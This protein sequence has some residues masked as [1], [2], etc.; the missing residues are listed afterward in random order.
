MN[1]RTANSAVDAYD[2]HTELIKAVRSK[3]FGDAED[4]LRCV[5][6]DIETAK[7][8]RTEQLL[9]CAQIFEVEDLMLSEA[10]TIFVSEQIIDEI[11]GAEETLIDTVIIKQD[12]FTPSGLIILEK[13]FIY[14]LIVEDEQYTEQWSITSICYASLD[15]QI[16]INLYGKLTKITDT[17]GKVLLNEND[18][19][20]KYE[21]TLANDNT[22]SSICLADITVFGFGESGVT[23]DDAL[24]SI[25]RFLIAF[26]RLTYEYLER[27][28]ETPPRSS[29]RRAERENRPQDGYIVNLKLR[30]TIYEG[31]DGEHSSPSY[32]FRVRGHWKR[33]YLRSRGFPVGDPRSYRHVYVKDYI[34]GRGDFVE[35]KRLVKV[36]K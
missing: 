22:R 27:T 34:K 35:S 15:E 30:R 7:I 28:T 4:R 19:D 2:Y 10:Q 13:P 25:K 17:S 31:K 18:S 16:N 14:D 21:Y 32:A 29:R 6:S 12:L 11:S 23:Y 8:S 3:K 5:I 9:L 20:T 24:L 36:E 26:F 1:L 33:A